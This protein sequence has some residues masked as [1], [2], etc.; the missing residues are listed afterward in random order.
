MPIIRAEARPTKVGPAEYFTGQVWQDEVIVG[1]AP[2][3]LRAS[4]VSF[5]PGARTAWHSHPFGQTLYVVSGIGRLQLEG[6]NVQELRP[7]DTGIIP[8]DTRHWHGAGPD[9]FFVHLAMAE[10]DDATGGTEWFEHVSDE[11]YTAAADPVA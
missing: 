1:T 9:R 11:A 10:I 3:R 8:H 4:N 2:S 5:S 6:E 7:G